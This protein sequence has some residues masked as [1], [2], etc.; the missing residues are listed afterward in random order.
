VRGRHRGTRSKEATSGRCHRTWPCWPCLRRIRGGVPT[1][2]GGRI[3]RSTR[4]YSASR[5][6][7][8]WVVCGTE[9]FTFERQLGP[10]TEHHPD[11]VSRWCRQAL[12]RSASGCHSISALTR[13]IVP[14]VTEAPWAASARA[15]SRPSP[16]AA[17]VMTKAAA[18][19][20]HPLEQLVGSGVPA[21]RAHHAPSPST[22]AGCEGRQSKWATAG[23]GESHRLSVTPS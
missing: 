5:S 20:V 18:R 10:T 19:Q 12:W 6:R 7:H 21:E 22:V 8:R 16:L 15:L 14:L 2:P 9:G 11:S 1:N 4:C 23:N 17:P 13:T 3:P